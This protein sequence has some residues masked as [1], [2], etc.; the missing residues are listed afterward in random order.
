MNPTPPPSEPRDATPAPGG[1]LWM[2]PRELGSPAND[3]SDFLREFPVGASEWDERLSR[4]RFVQLMGA[5]LAF[6]GLTGC[7][8]PKQT[9]VPYTDQP[10]KLIPGRPLHFATTL[11]VHGHPRGVVVTQHEGRPTHIAGNRLHPASQGANDSWTGAAL[12]D[13]Y[14]PDRLQTVLKQ[15][16]EST[17]DAFT[18]AITEA[19]AGWAP[20]GG[21][22]LCLLTGEI[23]S[24]TL[25]AQIEELIAKF[26]QAA[27]HVYE[28]LAEGGLRMN[29][30]RP[31]PMEIDLARADVIFALEAD[32]LFDRPDS[33]ALTR[34]FSRRRRVDE[35][36]KCNRLYVAET[37]PTL[38]GAKADHRFRV[39][40]GDFAALANAILQEIR[41]EISVPDARWPW[42][43][44]LVADLKAHPGR[45]LL[46]GGNALPPEA[47]RALVE[48]NLALGN[49]GATISYRVPEAA[50]AATPRPLRDLVTRLQAG[51][52][53]TLVMLGGNP[54]Y[55][56]PADDDF[57][58][59]VSRVPLT[60]H[61]T[62][63]ANE[64]SGLCRWVVNAAH[65]LEAW[66]DA[67][68]FDG[69]LSITQ[70]LIAPLYDGKSALEVLATLIESPGAEGYELVRATWNRR[71]H[72]TPEAF[73]AQWHR[74][75]RDGVVHLPVSP[76]AAGPAAMISPDELLAG[77]ASAAAPAGTMWL[78][79]RA[80]AAVWDGRHANN[81]WLQELPDPVTKLTWD[82]AAWL[83]PATA[84][85]L[86]VD[87]GDVVKLS[88]ND[89]HLEVPV[90]VVPGHDDSSITLPLGY[91]RTRAGRAGDGVGFNAYPLRRSDALWQIPLTD[92]ERTGRT[93]PLARTQD[94]FRLEGRDLVHVSRLDQLPP[95]EVAAPPVPPMPSLYPK[96]DYPGHA[97]AMS[98]DL[99]TCTGCSACVVACQS[100]NNIPVV[101]KEQVL[102]RRE[103][104][105][106]RIDRYYEGG[107]ENPRSHFQPVPCMQCENAPCEVVCPVA[108]TQHDDEGL[109][110]MVYNRCVGTRYCS[111]NCPY[112]V[113]RFNFLEYNEGIPESRAL[114]LNPNVT[115]RS[116]GVM[117]KCTYCV[118][119]IEEARIASER[120]H[121]PFTGEKIVTACQAACPAEAIVFGDLN[122][123]RSAVARNRKKPGHYALLAELDTRPRTTY[124]E[125]RIN[126]NPALEP[127]PRGTKG[128]VE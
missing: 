19:Q 113:R 24:P 10:E 108:A 111:N 81:G 122:D 17:W 87:D 95:R 86:K 34:A 51:E 63:F 35:V 43:G 5:S 23:N 39:S 110:V 114:G 37:C 77:A 112:K 22:G 41:E 85:T 70:P 125:K 8:L 127:L 119:R 20:T 98:I 84:A 89:T 16:G 72:G 73:E 32:F 27:W 15:G 33:L 67:R 46:L 68:S 62:L 75:L 9:L 26:P 2:D 7:R 101:G 54:V 116:R 99:N 25:R 38:T 91:G 36:S 107:A 12:L 128:D 55:D 106:I 21:G 65:D 109:N 118:Q 97:W 14:D 60:I 79:F 18:Q 82:N 49:G 59:L 80:S 58:D 30:G 123:P 31:V 52:V 104:H 50:G 83:S 53:T 102:A 96:V 42:L 6:A 44:A 100:E 1:G 115:V 121:R 124:L 71:V 94:H 56:A 11:Q 74:W 29:D 45:S 28:P 3:T 90:L 64:T 120:E 93:H 105:W 57:A 13:L 76:G 40:P 69:T 4:R 47:Q 78:N 48:A 103:M 92:I 61:H 66:G 126:P 117:E 88:V